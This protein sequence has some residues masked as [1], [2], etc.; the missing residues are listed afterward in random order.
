MSQFS[1]RINRIRE[2]RDRSYASV[3]NNPS[4]YKSLPQLHRDL[5]WLLEIVEDYEQYLKDNAAVTVASIKMK[6]LMGWD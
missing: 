5:Y 4:L 1:T 6:E 3:N 2:G